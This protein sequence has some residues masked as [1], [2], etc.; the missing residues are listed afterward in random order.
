VISKTSTTSILHKL[1]WSLLAA[2]LIAFFGFA[3]AE[4]TWPGFILLVFFASLGWYITEGRPMLRPASPGW[5]GLP[6]WVANVVLVGALIAAVYRGSSGES[7]VSAFTAFLASIIVLKLWQKRDPADY[8]QML[9]MSLFL[10]IGATLNSNNVGVGIAVFAQTLVLLLS[11]MF[12]QIW[13][14]QRTGGS[15]AFAPDADWRRLRTPLAVVTTLALLAAFAVGALVFVLVPRQPTQVPGLG[16]FGRLM[17]GRQVGFTNQVDLR[18]A[19]ITSESR[20]VV[21]LAKLARDADFTQPLGSPDIPQYLRGA[22][23]DE[24]DNGSWREPAARTERALKRSVPVVGTLDA[25]FTSRPKEVIYQRITLQS[26]A[27]QEQPVFHLYRGL[28]FRSQLAGASIEDPASGTARIRGSASSYVYDVESAPASPTRSVHRRGKVTYP[29]LESLAATILAERGIDPDWASRAQEDDA[30]AIIALTNYLRRTHAYSLERTPPPINQDPIVW[31]LTG[32]HPGS[33][34]YFAAALASLCHSVGIDARVIAGY[35]AAEFD[36]STNQYIVRRSD[37]HAWVEANVGPG[38][39]RTYDATPIADNIQE[40]M[41]ER[42]T[43]TGRLLGF[44]D[45]MQAT[46]NTRVVAF[47]FTS[48]QR[49]FSVRGETPLV[50]ERLSRALRSPEP[51]GGS[52]ISTLTFTRAITSLLAFVFLAAGLALVVWGLLRTRSRPTLTPQPGWALTRSDHRQ[53]L[54]AIVARTA[55]RRATTPLREW[56]AKSAPPAARDQLLASTDALYAARF[57]QGETDVAA[58]LARLDASSG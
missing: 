25:S 58:A 8:G 47:D 18:A 34:E 24:Y 2:V 45:G 39:W 15:S 1:R 36:T 56:V 33:C 51:D 17:V 4:G 50:I 52:L 27:T 44:L 10:T 42:F 26:G 7:V 55:A 22:V 12:L 19:G 6:R 31:W 21:L 20:E 5:Q 37:A 16:A 49:L 41:R 40:R 48:Q 28:S 14:A 23:L 3:S 32:K 29:A 46:W 35:L 38:L 54:S 9:T 11:A 30:A 53:L 43:I 57:A 13:T